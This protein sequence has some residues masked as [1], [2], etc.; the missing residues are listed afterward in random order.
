[1][2]ASAVACVNLQ[3]ELLLPPNNKIYL[4]HGWRSDCIGGGAVIDDLRW[5]GA[6]G[7]QADFVARSHC[8]VEIIK[9]EDILVGTP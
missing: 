4:V 6:L 1:M 3:L 8:S 5:A 7:V 9:T 2:L